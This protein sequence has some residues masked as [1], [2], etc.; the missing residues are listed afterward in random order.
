MVGGERKR[1]W[2]CGQEVYTVGADKTGIL[3]N[4][5]WIMYDSYK[6]NGTLFLDSNY[7]I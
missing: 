7:T 5:P 3:H 2:W 1:G 4:V 6:T